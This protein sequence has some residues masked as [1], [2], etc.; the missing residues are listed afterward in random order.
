ME[1]I[2]VDGDAAAQVV[3]VELEDLQA[4]QCRHIGDVALQPVLA[5]VYE[6]KGGYLEKR[7]GDALLD[8]VAA[9]GHAV[10]RQCPFP[11]SVGY[12]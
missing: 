10:Q 1:R 12:Q 6:L 5:E 11:S 9:Q 7:G 8:Q 4:G 3:V 2:D